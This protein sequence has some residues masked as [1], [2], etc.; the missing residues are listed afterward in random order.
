MSGALS[1][2]AGR[3]APARP[4]ATKMHVVLMLSAFVAS[5]TAC[6]SPEASRTRGGGPGAD[7]Q[8]RPA[9]VMMHEGSSQYWETPVAID[10]AFPWMDAAQQARQLSRP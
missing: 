4:S 1:P 5:F 9:V 2:G 10:T 3:E 8:N 7:P 6:E